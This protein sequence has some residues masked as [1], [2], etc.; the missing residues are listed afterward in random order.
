MPLPSAI[1]ALLFDFDGIIV[2]SAQIR[3][4]GFR[5]IFAHESPELVDKLVEYHVANGG[6][7]RYAKIRWFYETLMGRPCS[8][9]TARCLAD[10]FK[11]IMLGRMMDPMLLVPEALEFINEYH[12]RI[13]MHIV[14]GSDENELR[15]ICAGLGIAHLFESIHG[16]P[17][18]KTEL[19]QE[20]MGEH[21]YD[22]AQTLF[23]GDAIYDHEA[24]KSNGLVFCGTENDALRAISDF[25]IDD[26]RS[27]GQIL[28]QDDE[29]N[30]LPSGF[31]TTNQC[32]RGDE[33]GRDD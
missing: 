3:I 20:L 31:V 27:F 7:S 23:I 24:A 18:P 29:L 11:R 8:A 12:G 10:R 6:I 33:K 4:D 30:R 25:Y 28:R 21:G 16:S 32:F 9:E 26:F 19:V 2:R 17:T 14:S 15:A 13:P 22:P 1:T 5:V